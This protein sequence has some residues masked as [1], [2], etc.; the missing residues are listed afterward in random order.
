MDWASRGWS[1]SVDLLTDST[2]FWRVRPLVKRFRVLPVDF[3]TRAGALNLIPDGWEEET[4]QLHRLNQTQTLQGLQEEFGIRKFDEK[5]K[6]FRELG[7]KPFS[8]I[9]F[10]NKFFA[11]ARSAFVHGQYY[12]ALTAVTSLGERVLNNLVL[13][14]R[15]HYK[16]SKSYKSIY[17]KKSSGNWKSMIDALAEWR[18]LTPEAEK[19]FRILSQRRN[20]AL[21]FNPDTEYND[22]ALALEALSTFGRIIKA[23]FASIG[24][25]PWLFMANGEVYIRKSCEADPFVRLVYLPNSKHL[26]YKH[27]VITVLP[28]RFEDSEPYAERDIS[29]EEFAQLRASFISKL[30][31]GSSG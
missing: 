15:N 22:R 5:L 25:L 28:W 26:G 24:D 30:T 1:C 23:Q 12:P 9:T 4:K 2:A 17:R 31:T 20:D 13:R 27:E 7:N 16:K 6:N 29:D 18:V 11:Q 10:H 3:D 14:L 19:N 21:H 8:V